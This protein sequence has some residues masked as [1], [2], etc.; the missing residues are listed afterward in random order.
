M[1]KIAAEL[2]RAIE[3][4]KRSGAPGR[5]TARVLARGRGWR[6]QD[7]VCTSGPADRVFEERH[8]GVSIAIVLAGTFGYRSA[9]GCQLM[10]P[11]SLLLG[12][13]GGS[14]ECRHDH[15]EGDLCLSLQYEPDYFERLVDAKPAF[16]VSRI[17]AVRPLSRLVA[18]A[19]AG[20]VTDPESFPWEE[21]SVALAVRAIDL[22]N[23]ERRTDR[24]PP[25]SAY[26][27][28]ARVVRAIERD[29]D[30][31]VDLGALASASRLSPYHFLRTFERVTGV[32]P[33][34]YLLRARLRDAALR[35]AGPAKILDVAL[36][37]G[38]GDVSNFN[39]TFRAEF[40]TSPREYRRSHYASAPS[41]QP[42]SGLRCARSVPGRAGSKVRS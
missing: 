2:E 34:Q 38:F 23:D 33:H 15:G 26:E 16:R 11:G 6:V 37:S 36:D 14:F 13:A 39:R 5:A 30:Q 18:R 40:G 41:R 20:V 29:S 21:F 1:A 35:L 9:A 28:V 25:P 8:S 10:T 17:P 3:E 22:A 7:V 42:A 31:P 27:R 12:N 32:T 24:E 19:S 4:R